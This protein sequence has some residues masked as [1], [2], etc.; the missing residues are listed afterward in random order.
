MSKENKYRKQ[1]RMDISALSRLY[2]LETEKHSLILE[3][4]TLF[5]KYNKEDP[6]IK[7]YK[8][9]L[10]ESSINLKFLKRKI[11]EYQIGISIF[12]KY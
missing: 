7:L 5:I 11:R 8:D 1:L 12:N 9:Y 10:I 2:K 6:H 4:I 3:G